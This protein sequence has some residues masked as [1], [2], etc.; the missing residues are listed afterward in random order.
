[1][2][3]PED[4]VTIEP[5]LESIAL[6]LQYTRKDV[7]KLNTHICENY[8][9]KAEF[10]P[11]KTLVYGFTGLLLTGVIIAILSRVVHFP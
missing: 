7:R 9:K 6:H 10:T 4:D 11:V 5:T 2:S 3:P 8:V 1:M